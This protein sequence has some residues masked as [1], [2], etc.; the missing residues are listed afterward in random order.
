MQSYEKVAKSYKAQSVKTASPGKLVLMLFDGY[1]RFTTAAKEAWKETDIIKKNE[2]INNNL[3]RAQ[4]IVTE[5]QSSLD[6]SV[7]GD[8]PPTLYRL[9]DYVL[10]NLQQGNLQKDL[11]KIEEADKVINELRDAWAE[12]LTQNPENQDSISSQPGSLSLEA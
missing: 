1:L 10:T 6:L 3:I 8:L 7:P 11:Q 9:Y 4:N 2:G 5:L 12:M